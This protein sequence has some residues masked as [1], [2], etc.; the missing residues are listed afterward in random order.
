MH[1]FEVDYFGI[2]N[3]T[4]FKKMNRIIGTRMIDIL[5]KPRPNVRSSDIRTDIRLDIGA[6]NIRAQT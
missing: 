3:F 6:T 2:I 5:S 1:S 4:V